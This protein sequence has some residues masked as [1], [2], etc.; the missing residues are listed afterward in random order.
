MTKF[1]EIPYGN[2]LIRFNETPMSGKFFAVAVRGANMLTGRL[3][4]KSAEEAIEKVRSFIRTDPSLMVRSLENVPQHITVAQLDFNAVFGPTV[5]DTTRANAI[6]IFRLDNDAIVMEMIPQ[7]IYDSHYGK[8]PN[9]WHKIHIKNINKKCS[10]SDFTVDEV[11]KNGLIANGRY[12]LQDMKAKGQN[13]SLPLYEMVLDSIV[14][15]TDDHKK[16]KVPSVTLSCH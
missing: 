2:C 7:S 11:R 12:V 4:G 5:R 3:E 9:D 8:K 13:G 6:R 10:H 14:E 15:N 16:L 1:N